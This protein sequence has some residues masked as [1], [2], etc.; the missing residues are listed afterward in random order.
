MRKEFVYTEYSFWVTITLLL[1]L[2]FGSLYK[3]YY[4]QKRKGTYGMPY[5]ICSSR[6]DLPS[7]FGS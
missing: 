4:F 3:M 2:I 7:R 5:V 6:V 1:F